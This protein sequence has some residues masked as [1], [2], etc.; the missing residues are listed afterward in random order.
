MKQLFNVSNIQTCKSEYIN[1]NYNFTSPLPQVFLQDLKNISHQTTVSERCFPR[2]FVVP[3]FGVTVSFPP[4]AARCSRNCALTSSGRSSVG[5]GSR[6]KVCSKSKVSDL[7]WLGFD[8]TPIV[9][10]F[11]KLINLIVD[12]IYIP[13]IRI[14]Y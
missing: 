12:G 1:P 7:R 8:T 6:S 3:R 10:L 5:S 4:L 14:P 11:D 9:F 13:I 2:S